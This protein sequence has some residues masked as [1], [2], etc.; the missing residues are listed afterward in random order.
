MNEETDAMWRIYAP[1]KNGVKVKST[2]RKLFDSL[3][4]TR[5]IPDCQDRECFVG[6]V[7]YADKT[8]IG[9]VYSKFQNNTELL[10]DRSMKAQALTLLIKREAFSHEREVRLIYYDMQR[11]C[12]GDFFR[13][14]L[15]PLI[16]FEEIIFDPR[17][18]V[19]KYERLREKL[20][21]QFNYSNV[22]QSDLYQPF[23]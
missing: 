12:N 7:I 10:L 9:D 20:S 1:D 8:E 3:W 21:R 17:M 18:T 22:R 23:D 2:I 16:F 4:N 14:E 6:K 19:G 15:N 11:E 5:M 13:Y